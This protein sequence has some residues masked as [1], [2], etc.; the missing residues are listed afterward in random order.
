MYKIDNLQIRI[1]SQMYE[2]IWMFYFIW[3]RIGLKYNIS[4]KLEMKAS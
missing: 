1:V 3:Y 4:S 2:I